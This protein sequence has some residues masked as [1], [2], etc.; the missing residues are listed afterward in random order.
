MKPKNSTQGTQKK[1]DAEAV[2][3]VVRAGYAA[4]ATGERSSCCGSRGC[5]QTAPENI[6]LAVGYDAAS[7]E[8]LPDGANMG[9]SCGNPVAIAA[10]QEGQTV[11]DLGS[12]GGFDAFQAGVKV[13]ETGL[14]IGVDMTPEMLQKARKNTVQYRERTGLDNVEFRLGEIEHLPVA[15]NSVDVV[16]SNC[17]INL[18]PN[19]PQ[20]WREVYR[21]LKPGASVSVSDLALLKPLPESVQA[22]TEALVGCVAGAALVNETKEMLEQAGFQDISLKIETDYIRQ[23]QDFNDP[24]YRCVAEAL[25]EGEN[26]ADYVVSLAIVARK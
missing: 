11:L 7:L 1:A 8:L 2:R 4:I 16:L 22:M 9:L 23:Q 15:D 26:L 18:S 24:T 10:L 21:V 20:V 13:K 14:V 19:K 6:A 3:D 25:P 12:G 17:V 5:C